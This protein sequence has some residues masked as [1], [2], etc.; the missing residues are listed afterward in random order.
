MCEI[1]RINF[2]R[3]NEDPDEDKRCYKRGMF[4][5]ARPDGWKWSKTELGAG[6]TILK[7][8]KIPE[9]HIDVLRLTEEWRVPNGTSPTGDPLTRMEGRRKLQHKIEEW[10]VS[11]TEALENELTSTLDRMILIHSKCADLTDVKT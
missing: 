5:V 2:D 10:S 7:L 9:D 3:H 8:P 4:I 6:Y 11:D 1:L